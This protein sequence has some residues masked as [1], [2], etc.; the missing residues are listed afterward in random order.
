[1]VRFSFS[2]YWIFKYPLHFS[3]TNPNCINNRWLAY[4]TDTDSEPLPPGEE[5]KSD[6]F[7]IGIY[8]AIGAANAFFVLARAI[9][10]AVASI[11]SAKAVHNRLLTNI[12]RVPMSF[13]D[14]TPVGRILNRF[15]KDLYTVDQMLP[16]TIS[17]FVVILFSC[18]SILIVIGIITPFFFT[19]VIPLSKFFLF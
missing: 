1:M 4:W 10:F 19:A 8:A 13:Y 2:V 12:L 18:F 3:L 11:N 14:T 5:G 15:S 9:S 7:Y 16:R 17:M 6:G